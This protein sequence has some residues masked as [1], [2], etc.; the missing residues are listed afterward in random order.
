VTN[1][2]DRDDLAV[3]PWAL[4]GALLLLSHA[5]EVDA[6]PRDTDA[7]L[8]A[9][10]CVSEAGWSCWESGDGYALHYAQLTVA[11]RDGISWRSAAR[12]LS[13]RA[14]GTRPTT[15]ARIAW[16]A[17][18]RAD[19]L[20]PLSWPAAPHSPWAQY[21]AR[22][23]AVLERAREVVTWGLDVHDEWSP[24]DDRPITWAA[25]WHTPSPGLRALDCGDTANLYYARPR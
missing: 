20:A 10:V 25:P 15:D 23:L 22:W 18:L 11:E 14:T 1:R 9:R 4:A 3:I 17:G 12:A 24:C 7:V 21:R 8:L 13:P 5:C 6:Q 16:V 19:A 2:R